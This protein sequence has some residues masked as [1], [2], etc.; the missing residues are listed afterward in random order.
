[1]SYLN[2]IGRALERRGTISLR[3]LN[4]V[5]ISDRNVR[6]EQETFVRSKCLTQI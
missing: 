3:P 2:P 4:D 5:F 1:M 6:E